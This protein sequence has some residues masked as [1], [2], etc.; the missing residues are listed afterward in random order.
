MSYMVTIRV[1]GLNFR[2][3]QLPGHRHEA[4]ISKAKEGGYLVAELV[5]VHTHDCVA[6]RWGRRNRHKQCDCGAEALFEI[7]SAAG[8]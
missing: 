7:A 8:E 6:R 2:L 3:K 1:R 5:A 4:I